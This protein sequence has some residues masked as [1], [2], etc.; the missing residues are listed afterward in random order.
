MTVRVTPWRGD[1][2]R[3]MV[4]VRVRRPDGSKAR[5][6]KVVEGTQTQARNW[7]DHRHA[8]LL[9]ELHAPVDV[10]RAAEQKLACMTIA[11]F[12]P[13]WVEKHLEGSLRKQSGTDTAEMIL[14]CHILPFVGHR[15][16]DQI[17]D[18][19]VAD[20]KGRWVKGGYKAP[21]LD[22]KG[23]VVIRPTK[24]RKTLNN[25]A[26]VLSSLL[27]TAVRWR[28][29]TGLTEMPCTIEM[30]RVDSQKTPGFYEHATYE[31]LVDGAKAVDPRIYAAVLL[32]GDG[33]L[34]RGEIIGLDLADVDFKSGRFT[35]V[36][37]VYWKK[38]VKY[39]DVVKGEL[40]KPVPCTP[41]LL[42]ALKAVRHMRG[43]R[44]FYG[45]D[46]SELTPK[47]L[48][49]WVM[50][51]ERKAGLPL[52]GR[53]HIYRHTFCSHLAM[54]GVPAKTIQELAR[55]TSLS[56]TMR[57]MHLSPSAKD[58]GIEMLAQSREAGGRPVAASRRS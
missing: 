43:P 27:H 33:G 5:D 41:R 13:E 47:V 30:D 31:R 10:G 2:R 49:L 1:K 6:R 3:W 28:K 56:V 36:R 11:A 15:R 52:T 42:E 38:G 54:A 22:G 40:A 21:T 39:E 29:R 12:A 57:Y 45:D 23:E 58:E 14:R 7:G 46:G 48:K 24:S 50:K 18:D 8:T 44:V 17:T 9:G 20:L 25:R 34:R 4:D 32:G 37:S 19:V 55:H 35:P 53:M 51:A 26:S 16:L